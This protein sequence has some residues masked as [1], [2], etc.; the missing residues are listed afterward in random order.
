MPVPVKPTS[1]SQGAVARVGTMVSTIAIGTPMLQIVWPAM[2]V[3][4]AE[5]LIPSAGMCA[6]LWKSWPMERRVE[7]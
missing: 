2:N 1:P 3:S 7:R 4:A 5:A 6:A